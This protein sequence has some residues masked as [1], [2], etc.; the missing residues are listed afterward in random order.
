MHARKGGQPVLYRRPL[1]DVTMSRTETVVIPPPLTRE[2]LHSAVWRE[3][4]MTLA[5]RYGL[6]GRG[7]GKLCE[8]LNIPVPPRGYWA[9]LRAGQHMKVEKLPA[10][11]GTSGVGADTYVLCWTA[12]P[13]P[14]EHGSVR[15]RATGVTNG[16]EQRPE[17]PIA[18]AQTLAESRPWH[19]VI[20]LYVGA[21]STTRRGGPSHHT[22]QLLP[23]IRASEA[24]QER[25]LRVADAL[26][27]AFEVHGHPVECRLPR[28]RL[29]SR[30]GPEPITSWPGQHYQRVTCVAVDDQ[31][32]LLII[33]EIQKQV[34]VERDSSFGTRHELVPSGRL[35]ISV[36]HHVGGW[37]M[38]CSWED[39]RS[40]QSSPLEQQLNDV[41]CGVRESAEE[42]RRVQQQWQRSFEES[43]TAAAIA[44]D[45]ARANAKEV[46]LGRSLERQAD[47][48]RRAQVIRE[49]LVAVR[50]AAASDSTGV[51]QEITQGMT[52]EE[53]VQWG[54]AYAAS[55]DPSTRRPKLSAAGATPSP[56]S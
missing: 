56:S 20:T 6:S 31:D 3:P 43:Q 2:D 22:P 25:A 51:A 42:F 29:S 46:A 4:A 1:R 54:E 39:P 55:L 19:P 24:A 26:Y 40:A 44:A 52:L 34:R 37:G 7:L 11:T 17:P 53:W 16:G 45:L 9:R 21:Q 18:V 49:Y 13:T 12:A 5:S 48:W 41:V 15:G 28:P 8:R 50:G 10:R 30:G 38:Y 35:M 32:V 23:D 14:T 33:R 36:P 47:A 27:K